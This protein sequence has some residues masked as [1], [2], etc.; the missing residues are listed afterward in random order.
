MRAGLPGLWRSVGGGV[1]EVKIDFGPGYRIYCAERGREVV[2]LC[3]GTKKT[4][5]EDIKSAKR[6]W[7]KCKSQ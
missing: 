4:Q 1:F 3:A 7:A 5:I 6:Y 2:I